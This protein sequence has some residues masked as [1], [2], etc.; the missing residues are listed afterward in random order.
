MKVTFLKV[1]MIK[2]IIVKSLINEIFHHLIKLFG[3][4][5]SPYKLVKF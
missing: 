4:W 3:I 5:H 1:F 2:K